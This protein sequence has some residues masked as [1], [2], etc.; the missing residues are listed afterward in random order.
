[1]EF[2]MSLKD[3]PQNLRRIDPTCVVP[4]IAKA[5]GR[6]FPEEHEGDPASKA[7]SP[8]LQNLANNVVN[9]EFFALMP[10]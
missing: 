5:L 7:Y 4:I 9:M 8:T 3:S 1:M 6:Y 10:I 2:Y